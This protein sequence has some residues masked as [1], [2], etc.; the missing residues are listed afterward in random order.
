MNKVLPI[1]TVHPACDREKLTLSLCPGPAST[2][3]K[4]DS[5]DPQHHEIRQNVLWANIMA[6]GSGVE[7]YFGYEYN[8]SDLSLQD[9]RSRDEMWDQSRYALEFFY[10]N[11]VPFWKMTNSNDKLSTDDWLLLD[12][13]G[14][15]AVLYLRNGGTATIDL[16]AFSG[17]SYSVQWFDPIKGGALLS[18]SVLST[19]AG[20]TSSVGEPPY[21]ES[22]DWVVLLR[23]EG[24]EVDGAPAASTRFP[25]Q[26]PVPVP[27]ASPVSVFTKEPS[28]TLQVPT[29]YPS[30]TLNATSYPTASKSNIT[31]ETFSPG[32]TFSPSAYEPESNYSANSDAPTAYLK[33]SSTQVPSQTP[34]ATNIRSASSSPTFKSIEQESGEK[35]GQ[36]D[37]GTDSRFM[38]RSVIL[39]LIWNLL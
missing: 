10:V 39:C 4:P 31:A 24:C 14:T 15:Q 25:T 5:S 1:G 29:L 23:C 11:D 34:V 28:Q 38:G 6:G 21:N 32:P 37:S 27:S 3:V 22:Q 13:D 35:V 26:K 18:A 36:N 2:G 20:P 16:N 19:M 30:Y 9:F 12:I 7:Y 8:D 17:R 33:I